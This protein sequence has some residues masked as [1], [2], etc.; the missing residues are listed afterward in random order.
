[1]LLVV[2]SSCFDIYIDNA[3]SIKQLENITTSTRRIPELA[4]GVSY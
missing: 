1:M 2:P 4:G 3:D